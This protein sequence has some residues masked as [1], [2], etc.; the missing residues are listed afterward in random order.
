VLN[1]LKNIYIY[2]LTMSGFFTNINGVELN[3]DQIV[4][5]GSNSTSKDKFINEGGKYF[6]GTNNNTSGINNGTLKSYNDGYS[7]DSISNTGFKGTSRPDLG[8]YFGAQYRD[9]GPGN[10]YTN[11]PSHCNKIIAICVGAGGGGGSGRFGDNDGHGGGGGGSG[12]AACGS[13]NC[14]PGQ[15]ISI[16]VGGGGGHGGSEGAHGGTGGKTTVQVGGYQIFGNGG[17]GGIGD[18]GAG[19]AGAGAGSGPI[20]THTGKGGTKG[21]NADDD[22]DEMCSNA[23]HSRAAGGKSIYDWTNAGK[24]SGAGGA[25]GHFGNDDEFDGDYG[26]NGGGGW[27]RIYFTR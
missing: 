15:S 19:G 17:G 16:Y 25:G 24:G 7:I 23:Q 8:N 26:S 22:D 6:Q 12:S 5:G 1:G 9:Y 10:H 11:V 27:A 2:I 14:S 3:I 21:A 4:R 18:G 20:L 13:I